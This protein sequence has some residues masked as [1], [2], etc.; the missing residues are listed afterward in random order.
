MPKSA[1]PV[2]LALLSDIHANIDALIA[3]VAD[4]EQWHCRGVLCLG[5]V[6]GYGPE[7]ARCVEWVMQ[8]SSHT[9]IGNHE[10]LLLQ[11]DQLAEDNWH[12]TVAEPIH[13]AAKQLTRMQM[14]WLRDLP[15]SVKS[16]P[17]TL[18]H[19]ALHAPGEFPYIDCW[20]EAAESFKVQETF[21][22]FHGHTHVPII[23]EE[24]GS[25]VVGYHPLDKPVRLNGKNRYAVNVGSVGQPRDGDPRASYVLYDVAN[26]VLLHRRVEYDIGLA[27]SRFKKARLPSA[28]A[29]RLK[30]GN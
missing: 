5:D 23:W 15:L 16:D 11:I 6:V 27:I 9:V 24:R 10:A 12:P 7:P 22:S 4:L 3:V 26:R 21:I 8:N 2:Y 29:K 13:L 17:I 30:R 28:N 25:E 14:K 1:D 19:A 18:C 20:G